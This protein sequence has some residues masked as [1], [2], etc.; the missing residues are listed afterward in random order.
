MAPLPAAL[1][2][3]P[4]PRGD[5]GEVDIMRPSEGHVAGSIP[6]G[7]TSATAPVR[8]VPLQRAPAPSSIRTIV[9]YFSPRASCSGVRPLRSVSAVLAPA[10][11]SACSVAWW[12]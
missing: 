10:A 7:R 11:S 8:S 12:R 3:T 1:E 5:R 4:V 9:S 6:A 2:C